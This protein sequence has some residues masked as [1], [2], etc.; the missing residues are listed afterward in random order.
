VTQSDN[1]EAMADA[2]PTEPK[3]DPS[4]ELVRQIVYGD[5]E[6]SG[7]QLRGFIHQE[8]RK[9]EP[10]LGSDGKIHPNRRHTHKRIKLSK[11][12]FRPPGQARGRKT[13]VDLPDQTC[14]PGKFGGGMGRPKSKNVVAIRHCEAQ[15][16]EA[17]QIR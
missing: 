1:Y 13:L 4:T 9:A 12:P 3:L 14:P 16:A 17:I 6:I 5:E 11:L 15:S 7:Q 2:D 10:A 8:P